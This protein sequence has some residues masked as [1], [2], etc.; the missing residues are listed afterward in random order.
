[1]VLTCLLPVE[2]YRK[3]WFVF[4]LHSSSS[5]LNCWWRCKWLLRIGGTFAIICSLSG[6]MSCVVCTW[7][8]FLATKPCTDGETSW[9]SSCKSITIYWLSKCFWAGSDLIWYRGD[10]AFEDFVRFDSISSWLRRDACS[11]ETSEGLGGVWTLS[12]LLPFSLIILFAKR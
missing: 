3:F 8:R 9:K 5:S 12:L 6:G 1:M 11:Y 7:A 4:R 2:L 10:F